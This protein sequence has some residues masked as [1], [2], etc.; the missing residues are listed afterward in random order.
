MPLTASGLPLANCQLP[1]AD[2]RLPFAIAC[3]TLTTD[4]APKLALLRRHAPKI[5]ALLAV[6]LLAALAG[7]RLL[8]GPEVALQTV[9]QRDFVQTVVASGRVAT[10]HRADIGVQITGTVRA[11]P[12]SEGQEVAAGAPLIE[13]ESTELRAQL[14]QAEL[15]VQQARA[16]LRQLRELQAPMAEQGL[17]QA[18]AN[19]E[20]AAHAL[21]RSHELRAQGFIGQAALDETLRADQV[22]QAQLTSARQ[23]LDSA[24]PAGSDAAIAEAAMAQAQAGAD[25]AR[26]RLAYA[27][28]NA[29]LAGTVINRN[30]EPGDV[31]QPGKVLLLLSPAGR[32]ELVVQIDERNLRL[33]RL[34]LSALASADA[35]AQQRFDAKLD[36]INPA[37]DA[38]RGAVEVRLGVPQP[39]AYLKQD[40]TVSVDIEVARRPQALLVSNDA[41]HDA[42]GAAPWVLKLD[43][44]HVR[45]QPVRLGLRSSGLSEVLEGLRAGDRL[46]PVGALTIVDGAR[47]RPLPAAPPP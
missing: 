22:A 42:D 16:R 35:Y 9:Q 33:L 19:R 37:V 8:L 28:V 43:G 18:Q 41:L 4:P 3:P 46:V 11:V 39:P 26:A 5:A 40:M 23:Q 38:Q 29:P 45:R 10:P 12:V 30:V 31:V 1:I 27:T 25:A 44:R 7:P 36:F 24:R 6:L 34:G 32:T 15:A 20:A 14:K 21:L 17:R 13:L 2:C 47:V